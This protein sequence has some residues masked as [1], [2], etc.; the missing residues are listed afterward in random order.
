MPGAGAVIAGVCALDY[1]QPGKPAIDWDDP[2]ARDKP[3]KRPGQRRAGGAGGAGRAGR[4]AAGARG[5]GRA[6]PAGAG[7][8]TGRGAG[9]RQRR[10]GRPVADRPEGGPGPGD[11]APSTPRPGTPAS[12]KLQRRDGFRGHV[13]AE[14]E[15]G[16]V[17]DCE[18]TMAAGQGSTD[19]E[20]GVKMAARDRFAG[21]AGGTGPGEE[22]DAAA[23]T[24]DRAGPDADGPQDARLEVYG[25]SAYGSG[26]ARAAYRDA[27][28]GTVIKPGPLRP[29]V[30]GGF[31]IDDFTV[32]EQAG[33]VTCPAGVTRPMSART[34]TV[35]FGAAC[36]GCPLRA[37]CTTAKDGRLNDASTRTR[38]CCAPP[39][40][41]PAPRNSG[42]PTPPGQRSSGSSPGPPPRTAAG[43]GSATSAPPGTTPGCT[44][45]APRSTCA[46]CSG[47]AWPTATEPGSWPD[48]TGL[49]PGAGTCT[50]ARTPTA[51]ATRRQTPETPACARRAPVTARTTTRRVT[52]VQCRPRACPV[53]HGTGWRSTRAQP[54]Q[55]V[56]SACP[57]GSMWHR[58]GCYR[59]DVTSSRHEPGPGRDGRDSRGLSG[60]G[61]TRPGNLAETRPPRSTGH[62]LRDTS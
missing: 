40:P 58:A 22:P 20:N 52:V 13:A 50:Q 59:F 39:A 37:R 44:P 29:A 12:P 36:A 6:G 30:P 53:D 28:H 16:L 54:G 4:A 1:S 48:A 18:M 57:A 56:R 33:T 47:T 26:E 60:A 41:R 9:G 10:D 24:A 2:E 32:D 46:P 43:S 14:P 8:G 51:A 23:G 49:P 45:G 19:A 15:T 27:G 62:V 3:G 17:T 61:S 35:T 31:T 25:D 21:T 34:R 11:L 7:R 42:R 55:P 38:T 5:G